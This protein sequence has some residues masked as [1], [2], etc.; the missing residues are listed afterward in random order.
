MSEGARD[1]WLRQQSFE[2]APT[3]EQRTWGPKPKFVPQKDRVKQQLKSPQG[4]IKAAV[5]ALNISKWPAT[6]RSLLKQFQS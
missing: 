5:S 3:T 1:C 2:D 6:L 4:L